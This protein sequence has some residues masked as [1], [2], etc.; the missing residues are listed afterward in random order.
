MGLIVDD[1]DDE[2]SLVEIGAK[3]D[4]R[5]GT[6]LKKHKSGGSSGAAGCEEL[7]DTMAEFGEKGALYG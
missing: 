6:W 5:R 4:A 3:Q 7:E 1:V 2:S